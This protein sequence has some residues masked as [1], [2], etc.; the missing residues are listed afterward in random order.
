MPRQRDWIEA[1]A[2]LAENVVLQLRVKTNML[3]VTPSTHVMAVRDEES[4]NMI[5]QTC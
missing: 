3:A 1:R 4:V 2:P 5:D